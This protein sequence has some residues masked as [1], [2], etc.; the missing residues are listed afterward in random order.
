VMSSQLSI[1]CVAVMTRLLNQRR[2][3]SSTLPKE[4]CLRWIKNL[5]LKEHKNAL[6]DLELCIKQGLILSRPKKS[7][8]HYSLNPR[9]LKNV[10]EL[11]IKKK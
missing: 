3:G 5:P 2:I 10:Y 8:L 7:G 1:G 6:N 11:V 9:K 4:I